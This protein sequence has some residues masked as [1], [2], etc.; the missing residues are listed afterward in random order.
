MTA[1]VV[2]LISLASDWLT[3]CVCLALWDVGEAAMT[4]ASSAY[5]A[6]VRAG[7]I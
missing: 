2:G 1:L 6:I 7:P 5:A 4:A 3:F